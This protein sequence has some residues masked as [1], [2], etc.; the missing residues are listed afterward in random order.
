[1]KIALI[2]GSPKVKDS[3]SEIILNELKNFL[4]NNNN[5][6]NNNSEDKEI[7]NLNISEYNFR[8]NN[9][10]NNIIE[11]LIKT[12]ILVFSFPLYADGV[13]S[14]LVNCLVQL[15]EAFNSIK[16][17]DIKVYALVNCGFYE[18]EQNKLAIEIIENWCEKSG[19]K[20]GQGIG[21]GAGPLLHSI[22]NIPT[23]SGPKKNLGSA[24]TTISKNILNAS[25][26][27]NI[28]ISANFPRFAYKFAAEIGWKQAI[29]ANKLKVRDLYIRK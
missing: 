9:L 7:K 17:K 3:T 27:D 18:G 24:L 29:K 21:I 15:E 10:D 2:N 6:N 28:F 19:V 14:H 4:N 25:S 22:K 1:M 26:D 13:P 11:E 23:G 20:W 12:K 16:E 5:N 8:V